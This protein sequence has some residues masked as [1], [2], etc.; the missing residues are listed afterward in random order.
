VLNPERT[1]RRRELRSF[2]FSQNDSTIRREMLPVEA[3]FNESPCFTGR[4][5]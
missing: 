5:D 4:N 1:A 3:V 2:L